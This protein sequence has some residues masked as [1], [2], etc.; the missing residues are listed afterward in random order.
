MIGVV[1]CRLSFSI[2]RRFIF[3]TVTPAFPVIKPDFVFAFG[4]TRPTNPHSESGAKATAL[5]TLR[6]VLVHPGRAKR[7]DCVRFTA[8]F[9]RGP[10]VDKP[11]SE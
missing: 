6:D 2:F 7:L 8:A 10:I 4:G 9:P 11:P 5:Q 1:L 3:P